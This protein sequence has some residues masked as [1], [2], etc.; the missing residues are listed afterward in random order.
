MHK[1]S[2][3]QIFWEATAENRNG[4]GV[5][6]A[7]LI[8]KPTSV[9]PKEQAWPGMQPSEFRCIVFLD[10]RNALHITELGLPF[11]YFIALIQLKI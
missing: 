6:H 3:E 9:P 5:G 11:F 4:I 7:Y 10:E 1:N 8:L 2:S